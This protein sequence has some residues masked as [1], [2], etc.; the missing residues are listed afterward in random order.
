MD[1]ARER[2]QTYIHVNRRLGLPGCRWEDNI[3]IGRKNK[4]EW[5][6]QD[7]SGSEGKKWRFVVKKRNETK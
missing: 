1:R 7:E 4:M 5:S 6:G 3:T 2:G